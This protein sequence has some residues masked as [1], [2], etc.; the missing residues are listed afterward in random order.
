MTKKDCI[1]IKDLVDKYDGTHQD[2][3]AI[4]TAMTD[5]EDQLALS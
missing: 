4:I 1:E 5:G 3:A 2:V